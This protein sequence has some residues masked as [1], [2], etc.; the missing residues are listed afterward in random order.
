MVSYH[1]D[2][3][4]AWFAIFEHLFGSELC[5]SVVSP[6][7]IDCLPNGLGFFVGERSKSC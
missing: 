6:A 7:V 1:G 2:L 4:L 3:D 5:A